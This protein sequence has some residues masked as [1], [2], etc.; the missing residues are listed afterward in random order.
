M[1][2]KI[3]QAVDRWL[4]DPD[5]AEPDKAEIRRLCDAGDEK[6]L[7]DR[8]YRDLDF[9]TG[10]LRGVMGA[11]LNRMNIYTVGLAA[12][13][14]ANYIAKQGADAVR[15][16]IAIAYDCRH[17]SEV[18]AR[19]VACVMTANGITAHLFESL[20]PT[21]Q[22]S[23]AVRELRCTAGVVITASHN[24]PE[25][26]GLKAYWRDGGQ[27]TSPHD[28]VII[29]QVRGVGSFAHV[30][31]MDEEAAR[32][33]GLLRTIS[34]DMDERFLDEV[35]ATCLNR[36]VCRRQG[37]SLKIVYTSL[38][39]TGGT[40]AP[41]SLKRRGFKNVIEVA[42]QTRPDGAFPTVKS[43]NP[44]EGQALV[45]AIEL[46]KREGADLVIGTDPD[47]DR[48]GIAVRDAAGQFILLTGNQTAAL[49]TYYLCEMRKRGGSLGSSAVVLTT[50]V[51]GG[52]MK[53][54]ARGYG[55]E[56]VETLTGFKWI[57]E[58]IRQYEEAGT[59]GKPARQFI[60]GAEESYGYMP[61][62]FTRDKD[63]ITSTAM[64][65]E[66]AAF[67]ADEGKTLLD[68]MNDCYTRFGYFQE[69]VKS[70]T[71]PGHDGATR[72]AGVMSKL[73]ANPPR[74]LGGQ[75]VFSVGDL[76]TG[77]VRHVSSG[78]ISRDYD[79]PSSDVIIM[80]LADGTQVI[81]RPSGTEPKIKFYVLAKQPGTDL[82]AARVAATKSIEAILRDI[83]QL[84][85]A[86]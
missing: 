54:I 74:H 81:A 53:A 14:L 28:E 34:A 17:N 5:I 25:Y 61:A 77:D 45:M 80:T 50:I 8:F 51:T 62:P 66:A 36:D 29:E 15:G 32:K 57:A 63:A 49:L 9:G 11:G 56:V 43:P 73:R 46:A 21:P 35:D 76:L 42:E 39:G 24:P 27:V 10:G 20:R 52:L 6:E 26:N 65:A 18:F 19:R 58:K 60:F 78:K 72:I 37:A 83:E 44:E 64:I 7:I 33:A 30:R 68:V 13:G 84:V 22:L 40:L 3:R 82:A 85:A 12:Q 4:A 69:G 67:A 1:D 23:F 70:I 48:V 79:L 71:M 47:A 16:G 38:H 2:E 41:Q 86:S 31:M 59:P 55:V 75:E